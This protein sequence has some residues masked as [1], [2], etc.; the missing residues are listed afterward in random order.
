M[1]SVE[2][3]P[4]RA[5]LHRD[6]AIVMGASM[7]GLLAAR[8]LSETFER[9]TI[10]ERDTLDGAP[11]KG[12]PQAAHLHA[13]LARGRD[14]L[15]ELFPGLTRDLLDSG[16]VELVYGRNVRSYHF[17]GF[18]ADG[19]HG[20]VSI[21]ASRSLVER[22][23]LRRVRGLQSV[24]FADGREITGLLTADGA[25]RVAGVTVR[26]RADGAAETLA[27]DLVVDATG[28]GSRVPRWLVEMGYPA[29]EVS[30]VKVD[31]GYATRV[32]R[33]P[34]AAPHRWRSLYVLD[35]HPGS[36]RVGCIFYIEDQKWMAT[37][38]GPLG[39]HPPPDE[40]GYREFAKSLPSR[41][42]YDVLATAE[43]LGDIA[44]FRFPSNLRRRYERM[45]RLPEGLIVVGD[46]LCCFNPVYGQGMTAAAL[47]A[48]A[49]RDVLSA[50]AGKDGLP[51]RF[52]KKIGGIL[53][54]PWLLSTFEDWRNPR[55]EGARPPGFALLGAYLERIH[56]LSH[57]DPDLVGR[58]FRVM[59][60][61]ASPA[62]LFAPS[63]V[64]RV[65]R[66]AALDAVSALRG[67]SPSPAAPRAPAG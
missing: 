18:K 24:R 8:V 42:L 31:V 39:D 25:R 49:L 13:L 59:N 66:S 45:E 26:G 64:A 21:A 4:P 41:E 53:D 10:V 2:R 28:R 63:V 11:R 62:V 17:G 57:S 47:C 20:L 61:V 1:K 67:A 56:T 46:A 34:D 15:E 16:A 52:H 9:V 65:L 35:L 33:R 27:A 19:G 36:G 7:A 54:V 23:V 51:A 6:H 44:T 55:V 60:M 12:V 38:A 29:P 32:F 58:F 3:T 48:A 40:E 5:G 14:I 37:L 22:H 50:P 43:P 30:E